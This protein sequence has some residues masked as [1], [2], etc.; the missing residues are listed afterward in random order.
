MEGNSLGVQ[1]LEVFTFT[2]GGIGLFL[3]WETK[4]LQALRQ[5]QKKKKIGN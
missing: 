5:G 3:G 1:W 2:A 4:I